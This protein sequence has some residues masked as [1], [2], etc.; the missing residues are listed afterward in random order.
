MT[1]HKPVSKMSDDELTARLAEMLAIRQA[2]AAA[3][4]Q[5]R[6]KPATAPEIL[7]RRERAVRAMFAEIQAVALPETLDASSCETLR[8]AMIVV[9]EMCRRVHGT[10]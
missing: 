10:A 3:L 4:A 2:D 9:A 6:A 1:V 8:Q 5:R 7:E